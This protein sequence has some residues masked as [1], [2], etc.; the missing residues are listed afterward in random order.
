MSELTIQR[1]IQ[2]LK[3]ALFLSNEMKDK[4]DTPDLFLVE[5]AE[6]EVEV[7]INYDVKTG[8]KIMVIPAVLEGE[9]G[10]GANTTSKSVLRIKLSPILSL[11]E[12]RSNIKKDPKYS[13]VYLQGDDSD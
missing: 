12:L 4:S 11:E 2:E 6:V 5:S 8:L 1:L 3:T 10:A 7:A 9:L 13:S